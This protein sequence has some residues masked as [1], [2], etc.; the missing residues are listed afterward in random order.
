D[1][2]VSLLEKHMPSPLRRAYDGGSSQH[3][4]GG[5]PLPV[6][7][8]TLADAVDVVNTLYQARKYGQLDLLTYVGVRLNNWPAVDFILGRLLDAAEAM[9][10]I[11]LRSRSKANAPWL[12]GS[13]SSLDELSSRSVD[14]APRAASASRHD[15]PDEPAS[16]SLDIS[17]ARPFAEELNQR[18]MGEVWRALGS[19]V[20][21]AA[22]ASPNEAKLA[23]SHVFFALARLH[24]SGAISDKVYEYISPSN[25]QSTYRPPGMYLLKSSILQILSDAAWSKY[26]ADLADKAAAAGQESPFIP[27]KMNVRQLEPAVWMELILWCCVEQ[28]YVEEAAWL[29]EQMRTRRSDDQ[30]W[31]VK[32][33]DWKLMLEE[34]SQVRKTN[35][36]LEGKQRQPHHPG[37]L[38][39]LIK[40]RSIKNRPA[41]D[42]M[43]ER[44]ISV[45]VIWAL[46]DSLPNVVYQGQGSRGL[47]P[48]KLLS[49]FSPL[50][51]AVGAQK[52]SGLLPTNWRCNSFLVRMMESG[53]L[54]SEKDP[55]S[56]ADLL[57]AISRLVPPYISDYAQYA[58]EERLDE[59]TPSDLYDQSSA[60]VGLIEYNLRNF[61]SLRLCGQAM[62]S[63]A[64]LQD[65]VDASKRQRIGEFFFSPPSANALKTMDTE[66]LL[67]PSLSCIPHLSTVTFAELLDLITVSRTTKFGD[68]LLS[69]NDFDGPPIPKS[70]YGDQSIAPSIIRFAAATK[71]EALAD[72]VVGSLQPPLSVNTLRALLNYRIVQGQWDSVIMMLEYLRD[73]RLKSWGHSNVTTLAAEI[74]RLQHAVD[75]LQV[76]QEDLDTDSDTEVAHP[77]ESLNKATSILHRLLKGEFNERERYIRANNAIPVEHR[78]FQA[79]VLYGL[80]R[81]FLTIRQCRALHD[82][83]VSA[84]RDIQFR[85]TRRSLIP[86][87]PSTAFH[88]ILAA[89][90]DT[91]GS[92]AGK[93]LFER[94][95]L[96]NAPPED[97]RVH[98]GGIPRMYLHSER[99]LERGDPHFDPA[100]FRELQRKSVIPNMN[101]VRIILQKALK[102]YATFE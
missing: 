11:T 52:N 100:H 19:L 28:G 62:D 69:S 81:L 59:L 13:K 41:F 17:T 7:Q 72:S 44:T 27:V 54:N 32:S 99:F 61:A 9:H 48:R 34:P 74:I 87:I 12:L 60:A 39:I 1:A 2:W 49:I 92:D 83:A 38:D 89:V 98:H 10:E 65:I 16:N 45:E 33:L 93:Q 23:M 42:G 56:L 58:D 66:E 8:K 21:E 78:D 70:M 25:Y 47:A 22:D 24:T 15:A 76:K 30:R 53:G 82:V 37:P 71:N 75:T 101:T 67:G 5:D 40:E 64:W 43:G 68:W 26:E 77:V 6:T 55:H 31:S 90:V 80:H 94:V 50:K 96:D 14:F 91:Q 63:F 73:H 4:P 102:E 79:R 29:I 51:F 57:Q 36:E 85:P 95:C 35:V 97:R 3:Q 46:L 20:L 18:F 88:T 84:T 86:Y